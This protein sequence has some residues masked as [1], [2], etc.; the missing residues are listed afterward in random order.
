MWRRNKEKEEPAVTAVAPGGAPALT[1]A[2]AAAAGTRP[3]DAVF[4]HPGAYGAMMLPPKVVRVGFF[5]GRRRQKANNSPSFCSISSNSSNATTESDASPP[6]QQ[7]QLPCSPGEPARVDKL[8]SE[9]KEA[10]EAESLLR[11]ESAK[12]RAR[13]AH[14]DRDIQRLQRDKEDMT[15]AHRAQLER[16]RRDLEAASA[17]SKRRLEAELEKGHAKSMDSLRLALRSE[18]ENL[19]SETRR[20]REDLLRTR[21][22]RSAPTPQGA[23]EGGGSLGGSG[24]GGGSS[25]TAAADAGLMTP[26]PVLAGFWSSLT[27]AFTPGDFLEAGAGGGGGAGGVGGRGGDGVGVPPPALLVLA[28]VPL[29]CFYKRWQ[30]QRIVEESSSDEGHTTDGEVDSDPAWWGLREGRAGGDKDEGRVDNSS[31]EVKVA[32]EGAGGRESVGFQRPA[33][34]LPKAVKEDAKKKRRSVSSSP[35]KLRAVRSFGDSW[36]VSSLRLTPPSNGPGAVNPEALISP[37]VSKLRVPLLARRNSSNQATADDCFGAHDNDIR[38]L[39]RRRATSGSAPVKRNTSV[40]PDDGGSGALLPRKSCAPV[41]V[42]ALK[43]TSVSSGRSS[44]SSL[45]PERSP[46]HSSSAGGKKGKKLAKRQPL[47][48]QRAQWQQ[49]HQ[50]QQHQQLQHQ[51]Q[52]GLAKAAAMAA[53]RTA[54]FQSRTAALAGGVG[55]DDLAAS[56]DAVAAAALGADRAA[57]ALAMRTALEGLRSERDALA[58]ACGRLEADREAAAVQLREGAERLKELRRARET[59]EMEKG[60][61]RERCAGLEEGAEACRKGECGAGAGTVEVVEAAGESARELVGRVELLE[62]EREETAGLVATKEAALASLSLK[63]K[64]LQRD[65]SAKTDDAAAAAATAATATAAAAA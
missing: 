64:E 65:L 39:A 54:G 35:M 13:K 33:A 57:G 5:A 23:A 32:R 48:L 12:L 9:A 56:A 55:N 21:Q 59:L 51:Q 44:S 34:V 29:F 18:T 31:K 61:L 10:K 62:K 4:S 17:E 7:E 38:A 50:H 25:G 3:E 11:A 40:G 20:L 30:R 63:I 58:N 60:V 43:S 53:A 2:D 1:K 47:L 19:A 22:A 26:M 14:L 36:P 6:P 15:E 37:S 46:P 41:E 16:L 52:Q 8:L 49:Q 45:S 27:N 28:A 42:L 24:G